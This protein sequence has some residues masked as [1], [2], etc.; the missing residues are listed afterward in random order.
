ME[1]SYEEAVAEL[2][3]IDHL[4]YV[5]LKYT[6]TVDM[7]KHMLDRM[8]G[9]FQFGILCLLKK[10]KIDN[11]LTLIPEN[12]AM[13]I[14]LVLEHYPDEELKQF[15]QFYI[16][17]RKLTK[18]PFSRREEFRRHVTMTATLDNNEIVEIDIDKLKEYYDLSRIFVKYLKV[19]IRGEEEF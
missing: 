9:M 18:A 7:M 12:N 13:R 1:E 14:A 4:F 3:R 2:K 10:K 16:R 19:Q 11:K 17:L 5:S 8:V 6:R 15:I